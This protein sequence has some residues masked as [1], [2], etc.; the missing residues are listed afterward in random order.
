MHVLRANRCIILVVVLCAIAVH[1]AD[2]RAASAEAV[3][4]QRA[5]NSAAANGGAV[6]VKPAKTTIDFGNTS[7]YVDNA[8]VG[9]M[10]L[11]GN[12]ALLIFEPGHGVMVSTSRHATLRNLSVDYDPPCFA[13]GVVMGA[14][15]TTTRG[16]IRMQLSP[17]YPPLDSAFIHSAA[18]VKVIFFDAHGGFVHGQ[19]PADGSQGVR[20]VGPTEWNVTLP[21]FPRG[22]IPAVGLQVTVGPRIG[23]AGWERPTKAPPFYDLGVG[24]T[25]ATST[26]W[27]VADS[28]NVTSE[29]I[30]LH[31]AG[32]MAFLESGGECGHTY[33]GIVLTIDQ[34]THGAQQRT[35]GL[36]SSNVD[37]FH[38]WGCGRGPHLESSTLSGA[39]DDQINI[40]GQVFVAT[41]SLAGTLAHA[42]K[43]EIFVVDYGNAVYDPLGPHARMLSNFHNVIAGD[44]LEFYS[45]HTP[46]QPIPPVGSNPNSN[47]AA[48]VSVELIERVTDGKLV[49]AALSLPTKLH[50]P[51]YNVGIFSQVAP[52][53]VAKGDYPL[54]F[55]V[56]LAGAHGHTVANAT[57]SKGFMWTQWTRRCGSGA[58]IKNNTLLSTY[59]HVARVSSDDFVFIDNVV[60]CREP[61]GDYAIDIVCLPD[62]LQ[63]KFGLQNIS[64]TQN[65][66]HNCGT[67]TVDVFNVAPGG[68]TPKVLGLVVKDN[69]LL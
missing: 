55:K 11:N 69:Q 31:G 58:V 21:P 6:E 65:T 57:T 5:V 19:P 2:G 36:I 18:E 68:C 23:S 10:V 53:F 28:E 30:T 64:F 15:S 60:H 67:T 46:P 16:T 54:V 32:D 22:F 63:A 25:W 42:D 66:M 39:G 43:G 49:E 40:H 8:T 52:P 62:W 27:L 61:S 26:T 41:G 56:T 14:D 24:P 34:S 20:Q 9:N 48:P 38:S 59:D 50:A 4:L 12:G 44:V 51:P 1:L 29:A 17:G 47:A 33:R 45:V 35:A 7:L 3:A 37:A 13:Q